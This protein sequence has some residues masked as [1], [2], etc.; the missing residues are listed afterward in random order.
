MAILVN[1][2]VL[3]FDVTV[4]HAI[5][6]YFLDGAQNLGQE[7]DRDPLTQVLVFVE[8]LAEVTASAVVAHQVEVVKRL[9]CVVQLAHEWVRDLALDLLLC[10]H[11]LYESIVRFLLHSLQREVQTRLQMAH[12]VHLCVAALPEQ[13][14]PFE[15]TRVHRDLLL[16]V[17][18]VD[19]RLHVVDKLGVTV[20]F[21]VLERRVTRTINAVRRVVTRVDQKLE[22]VEISLNASQVQG[23]LQ[24]S[25]LTANVGEV[26]DQESYELHV[27]CLDSVVESR[28]AIS[29]LVVD[30]DSVVLSILD[31][32]HFGD[33]FVLAL[34]SVI[35]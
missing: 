33:L 1:Q 8:Q 5:L 19:H 27:L 13:P 14:D 16:G 28:H 18:R 26:S 20:F 4:D 6:V 10:N 22:Y 31:V 35:Y 32:N 29:V 9:E 24:F 30:V 15:I 2:D 7:F 34:F 23:R 11:K 12:K 21:C 17:Q 25:V 3:G